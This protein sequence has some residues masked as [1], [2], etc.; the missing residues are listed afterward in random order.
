MLRRSIDQL[1]HSNSIFRFSCS[2]PDALIFSYLKYH[3]CFISY[4]LIS[5]HS[6]FICCIECFLY[7]VLIVILLCSVLVGICCVFSL[8]LS[9]YSVFCILVLFCAVCSAC[10]YLL[11][12]LFMGNIFFPCVLLSSVLV[13]IVV[14]R[15]HLLVTLLTASR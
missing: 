3:I 9:F 7:S 14:R 6:T 11:R 5:A 8:V 12:L 4:L 2:S 1:E 10:W 13:F 15:I